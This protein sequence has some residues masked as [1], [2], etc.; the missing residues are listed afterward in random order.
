MFI[1]YV[2]LNEY[3]EENNLDYVG[4]YTDRGHS[5]W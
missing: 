1:K 5:Y 4:G 3:N 2:N